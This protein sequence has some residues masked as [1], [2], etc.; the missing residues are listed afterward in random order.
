MVSSES[1]Q[2]LLSFAKA[3]ILLVVTTVFYLSSLSFMQKGKE[4]MMGH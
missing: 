3:Y 2:H 1:P 4:I